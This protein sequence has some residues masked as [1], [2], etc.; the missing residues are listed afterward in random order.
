MCVI[1]PPL[2]ACKADTRYECT[3]FAWLSACRTAWA[4]AYAGRRQFACLTSSH[5]QKPK[6]ACT[7]AKSI[8]KGKYKQ[9]LKKNILQIKRFLGLKNL[10]KKMYI[11]LPPLAMHPL[12]CHLD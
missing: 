1:L 6:H 11:S 8:W 4:V 3:E 10:N 7:N 12:T 5:G 9:N 2:N